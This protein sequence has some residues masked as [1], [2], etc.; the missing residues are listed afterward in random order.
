MTAPDTASSTSR[1][2]RLF[3]RSV[4]ACVA[5]GGL[6]LF[7]ATRVWSI[8]VTERPGLSDLRASTTGASHEPWLVGLALVALAGGGAL[9]ATRGLARRL[10]GG[11]LALAG[12]GVAAGA[13]VGRSGL[14][15]GAAGAGAAIWP[16][17]CVAGAAMIVLGGL[18]AARQGH[19]WPAMGSRY[20]R[21]TVPPSP[22]DAAARSRPPATA[23]LNNDGDPAGD[24]VDT[25]AVWDAL[26]RGVDPT[27][28]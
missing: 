7:A 22:A 24:R 13:I 9:L 8:E 3:G 15:A 19:L 2:R 20:D 16:V 4:L 12:A 26:D 18:A 6:A 23:G 1:T 27:E 17:V 28:R 10:L 25:R 11:L 5:G 14:D 21:R